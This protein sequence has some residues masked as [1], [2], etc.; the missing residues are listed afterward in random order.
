MCLENYFTGWRPL[1][2]KM[3][4]ENAPYKECLIRSVSKFALVFF[5]SQTLHL[6][7]TSFSCRYCCMFC[8]EFDIYMNKV[9]VCL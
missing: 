3:C 4:L 7:E 5:Y 9:F 1:P 8:Y 2:K 6:W